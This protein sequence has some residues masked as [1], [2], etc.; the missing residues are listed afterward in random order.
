MFPT[1]PSLGHAA[2][3]IF[4]YPLSLTFYFRSLHPNLLAFLAAREIIMSFSEEFNV[5][6]VPNFSSTR[7][8]VFQEAGIEEYYDEKNSGAGGRPRRRFQSYKLK[9]DYDQPWRDDP[10]MKKTRINNWIV[11]GFIFVGIALSGFVC[12]TATW[13]IANN[14]V[15]LASLFEALGANRNFS[16]VSF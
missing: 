3:R 13:K 7:R 6:P 4:L 11:R 10:R 2:A 12:Y 9:G 16:T 8:P 15:C 14:P 5:P 1:F